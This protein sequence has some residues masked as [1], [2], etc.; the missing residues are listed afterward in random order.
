M[1][2]VSSLR[3]IHYPLIVFPH[4][5]TTLVHLPHP[6]NPTS[7]CSMLVNTTTGFTALHTHIHIHLFL[8]L[9][10]HYKPHFSY[11]KPFNPCSITPHCCTT[12]VHLPHLLHASYSMLVNTTTGSTALHTHIHTHTY[13]YHFQNTT[14]RIF[15][16]TNR[17]IH[18]ASPLTA[19]QPSFIYPI[20]CM[21]HTPCL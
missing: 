13:S 17:S 15:P 11:N 4:C 6:H 18:V 3:L 12:L 21:L 7:T 16:T 2:W 5:C 9:S 14:S 20:C 8:P 1:L 10:K 19:A